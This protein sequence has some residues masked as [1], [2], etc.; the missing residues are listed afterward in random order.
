MKRRPVHGPP[1]PGDSVGPYALRAIVG[2]GGMAAVH[3]A[4]GPEGPVAV[5][6]LHQARITPEEVKRFRREFETLK[7]LDHPHVVRVFDMGEQDGFPWLAM[8]LVEGTD[9]G[10]LIERW[11]VEPPPDRWERVAVIFRQLCEALAHVHGQGMIH[12]D[13]KPSNVLVG[14]DGRARLTDFGVVKDPDAFTTNLTVAGRLVGTVAF[15][16]PEQ[17]TGDA[18]DHRADLYS[19]GALLY[20]LLTCRRPIVADSIAGYLARHLTETPRAPSELDPRVPRRLERVAL[21]LLQKDP[22]RRFAS[23]GQVLAALDDPE[24]TEPL[25]MHGRD[26]AMK[27]LGER[28][29]ALQRGEGA[30]VAVVGPRGAGRTRLVTEVAEQ[31]RQAGLVVE[32]GALIPGDGAMWIVDGEGRAPELAELLQTRRPVLA[33]T[34]QPVPGADEISL[35][36][37]EREHVRAMLRDRGLHG[38][39]GAA[40]GRRLHDEVGG[41]PGT[42]VEQLQAMVQAGWLAQGADG[43]LRAA[44]PLETLRAEP[45]PLPERILREE[46]AFLATLD[47]VD[48]AVLDALAVLAAP[49]PL[50]VVAAVAGVPDAE[51]CAVLTRQAASGAVA[52]DM[53]GMQELYRLPSRRR[54]QVV[55]ECVAPERRAG[56]HRT[57]AQAILA[58]FRRR[59]GAVADQAAHH[60]LQAGDPASAYPLL[61]T[62]AQRALRRR[63]PA[64]AVAHCQRA[65]E[66]LPAAE[67]TTTALEAVRLRRQLHQTFGDGLRARGKADAA[68]DAYAQAL[69]AARQEGSREAVGRAMAGAGIVAFQRGRTHDAVPWLEE[70]VAALERGDAAWPEAA[71]HLAVSRLA[72]GDVGGARTLWGLLA[73][74]GDATGQAVARFGA[75]WGHAALTWGEGGDC[76]ALLDRALAG[77]REGV[78]A[79]LVAALLVTRAEVALGAL[80]WGVAL[81][82][83]EQLDAMGEAGQLAEAA[84]LAPGLR[85]A[86]LHIGNDAESASARAEDAMSLCRL[87]RPPQV[88]CWAWPVRLLAASGRTEDA[89]AALAEG[90]PWRPEPPTPPA[91]RLG[92]LALARARRDRDGA[93]AAAREAQT[94]LAGQPGSFAWHR[95]RVEADCAA[96]LHLAGAM[97]EAA[98]AWRR[99]GE[100]VGGPA[101]LALAASIPGAEGIAGL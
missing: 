60:L 54:A 42:V 2:Q 41:L 74:L 8:E 51:A 71:H 45:L 29:G 53:D 26:E 56:L 73:E 59:A 64:A 90:G 94:S 17:I 35:G 44:R 79:E 43:V 22:A 1:A 48:R 38:G 50:A 84:W 34:T 91:A 63:D 61:I 83:S 75:A 15:M 97:V 18:S 72:E 68:A 27:R 21:R 101:A 7:R 40:L 92:L 69:L 95:A 11:Q 98:A 31:A 82:V 10:A 12:R 88:S 46:G 9:L 100:A 99:V 4:E 47:P 30:V 62:A 28:L 55:Y 57:A 76:A 67:A 85:A 39:V 16:A 66:A 77:P 78:P 14:R 65:L 13:L 32:T 52:A 37:L 23:A 89:E 19:L 33:V 25:P 86:A 96:A 70:G 3:R 58:V 36:P 80:E 93:V 5:K 6:I 81:R 87:H 24:G 20:T 49:S